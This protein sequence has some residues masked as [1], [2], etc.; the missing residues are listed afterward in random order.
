MFAK[1][2]DLRAIKLTEHILRAS[3]VKE[4]ISEADVRLGMADK[5]LVVDMDKYEIRH[6][7]SGELWAKFGDIQLPGA[8]WRIVGAL[9]EGD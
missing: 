6:A 7:R 3:I 9:K 4:G 2:V 8:T 1:Q 5:T